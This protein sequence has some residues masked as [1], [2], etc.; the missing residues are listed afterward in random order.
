[1]SRVVHFEI[2][3]DDTGRAGKFYAD[4]F[5][6]RFQKWD[7]PQDYWLISTGPEEQPGIN[8]GM[9]KRRD[10]NGSVY[11]TIGI[12][13][14]DRHIEKVKAAGGEIVVD[15]MVI[16]GVG[17]LAYFKD[18]EGNVFGMIQPDMDAK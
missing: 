16:P 5:G 11:N 15:K 4:V 2:H 17:W 6:W 3:V 14:I 9:M 12:D 18:T 10:P 1:M 8:G 13:D 7:G